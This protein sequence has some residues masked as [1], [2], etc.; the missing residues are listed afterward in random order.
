[1]NQVTTTLFALLLSL[2]GCFVC[3]VSGSATYQQYCASIKSNEASGASGFV[4][5]QVLEGVA[6]YS[7]S[8]DLNNF[9]IPGG[10]C[11]FS[12]GLTYHIHSY[13][14]NNNNG[15]AA[16]SYCAASYTGGH[17]DPNL[18]CSKYSQSYTTL[19]KDLNRVPPNYNYT[20]NSTL[21]NAGEYARC[22]IG[23][24]SGKHGTA[25]PAS[26]TNLQFSISNFVDYLPPYNYNYGRTDVNSIAWT[27]F[28]FHC[29][30]TT[31]RLVCAKFS[32]QW[33]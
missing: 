2:L 28:I 4:S 10:S 11:D 6:T 30:E 14:Q 13:W 31:S 29:A 8:L 17:F 33:N 9:V 18:A 23:D 16:N 22:E 12:K 32:K 15:S 27:S 1:M 20:C 19:C 5:L 21:Y 7:F 24:T 3:T 26:S 25:Y